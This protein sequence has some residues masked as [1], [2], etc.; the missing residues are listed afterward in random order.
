[1]KKID[2]LVADNTYET[3]LHFAKGLAAA[4]E[5]QGIA[6]RLF[7]VSDGQFYHAFYTLLDDPPDLTCSFSDLTIEGKPLSHFWTIPHLS[8]LID[9]PIYFLH[10]LS[11]H[12]NWVTCV[13]QY[14]CAFIKACGF[15]NHFFLPHGADATLVTPIEKER[16]FD[17]VFFGTCIDYEALAQNSSSK[18]R[19]LIDQAAER[20]LSP[21][22]VSIA[23]ALLEL[24]VNKED[25]LR[26]HTQVDHYTRGKDRVELIKSLKGEKVNIWGGG[27]WEKYLP[28]CS[29]HPPLSF[30]E[31]I[32][33]MKE[34]KVVLNSSP[35]FKS[36][37]HERI[38][39]AYLCGAA[40]YT[41]ET[42][43]LRE[44]FPHLLSYTFGEY[45]K[46]P[47]SSWQESATA[48]QLRTLACHTWDARASTLLQ[49]LVP[50]FAVCK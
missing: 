32:E 12:R 3:T 6:V 24:G 18:D 48:G 43:Y 45:E 26:L 28:G 8:F 7:G 50:D 49:K 44:Q 16:R 35:R 19:D 11:G 5:R 33:I 25:L 15:P 1:M 23:H 29:I 42:P 41:G 9:P 10:Q 2:L 34:S 4:L 20:V 39:Y 22:G 46:S 47:L 38:L 31:T 30:S 21:A 27:P 13:D 36:G 40:A 14:D 17:V 37:S